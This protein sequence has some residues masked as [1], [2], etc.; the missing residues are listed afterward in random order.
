MTLEEY[1]ARYA[2]DEDTG[3]GWEA[4]DAQFERL[5]S[6]Q[7]PLHWA[8]VLH[9]ILGGGPIDGLSAYRATQQQPHFHCVSYGFSSLYYDEEAVKEAA[10]FSGMGFELTFRLA[11]QGQTDDELS[12]IMSLVQNIGQYVFGQNRWF[13]QYHC[14]PINGPICQDYDTAL[15]GLAFVRDPEIGLI[16]TPHGQV[17]FLQMV[18]LTQTEL[19]DIYGGR[20]SCQEVVETLQRDN[21]LLITDLKRR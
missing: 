20:K 19:D 17:E 5:Y 12:W 13:E 16:N 1:Q 21:P 8:P 7:T 4:I 15:T 2:N 3:P 10:E 9:A 18:G 14:L 6:D 11:D